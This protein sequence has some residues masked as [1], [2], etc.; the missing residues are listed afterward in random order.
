MDPQAN[1]ASELCTLPCEKTSRQQS[2]E[3]PG[4]I[5]VQLSSGLVPGESRCV[6]FCV[7]QK[8]WNPLAL[9]SSRI[10]VLCGVRMDVRVGSVGAT[11]A[12]SGA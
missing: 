5:Q 3:I 12:N 4:Q 2:D 6:F 10:F 11:V 7:F 1:L 9:C 8:P